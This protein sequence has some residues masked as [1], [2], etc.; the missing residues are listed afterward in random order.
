MKRE[1][2]HQPNDPVTGKPEPLPESII[3]PEAAKRAERFP[4]K[5]WKPRGPKV[6]RKP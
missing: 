1:T 2:F 4:K 6:E 3:D 5:P